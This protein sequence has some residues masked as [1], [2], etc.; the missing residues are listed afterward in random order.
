MIKSINVLGTPIKQVKKE[1][2]LFTVKETIKQQQKLQVATINAEFLVKAQNDQAFFEILQSS[3]NITDSIA[4]MWAA[5]F[6]KITSSKYL[7]L[8]VLLKIILF[9]PTIILIPIGVLLYRVIPERLAGADIFWDLI[10][11]AE[12]YQYKVF[13]LGAGEGVAQKTK[14]ILEKKYSRLKIVGAE[15][16]DNLTAEKLREKIKNSQANLLFVA[17]GAPKQ[18]KWIKEN[19]SQLNNGVVAI[20]VGG[21][22]DF[23]SGQIKR[24][25]VWVRKIGFEWLYRLIQEPKKR[26]KR[27]VVAVFIFPWLVLIKG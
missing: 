20:G 26:F 12:K 5:F 19:L 10:E 18:E 16:G 2:F 21:T 14:L 4:I 7:F 25:P 17:Y 9:L 1:Q 23:V 6:L 8:R 15:M 27:I 3:F 13:L 22:F 24:A 11:M